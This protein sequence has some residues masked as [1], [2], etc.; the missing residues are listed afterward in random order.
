MSDEDLILRTAKAMQ[1]V[2]ETYGLGSWDELS[3]GQILRYIEHAQAAFAV[4]SIDKMLEAMVFKAVDEMLK[5]KP[6]G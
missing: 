1:R 4:I 2:D 5:D 3:P 6:H